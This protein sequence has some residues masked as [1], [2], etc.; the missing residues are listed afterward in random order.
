MPH[1]ITIRYITN[2][3][4]SDRVTDK[5]PTPNDPIES[6]FSVR[7]VLFYKPSVTELIMVYIY[8]RSDVQAL[9]HVPNF[10]QWLE[11]T[12]GFVFKFGIVSDADSYNDHDKPLS[13]EYVR[14]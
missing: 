9:I 7:R 2:A 12:N 13:A 6:Y 1:K 14:I 10:G 4:T 11:C 3:V 5:C 8:Q